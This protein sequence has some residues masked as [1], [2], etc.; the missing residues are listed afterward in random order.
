MKTTRR[1]ILALGAVGM[2]ASVLTGCETL[3]Q[4]L[5]TAAPSSSTPRQLSQGQDGRSTSS[6]QPGA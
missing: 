1:E 3:E 2:A 5:T 4:R 6:R